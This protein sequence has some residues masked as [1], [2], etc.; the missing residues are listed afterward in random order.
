MFLVL[1]DTAT[2]CPVNAPFIL[3]ICLVNIF[4]LG[5]LSAYLFYLA[6][7]ARRNRPTITHG[8]WDFAGLAAGL[9]GFLI[10]GGGLVLHLF[11]SNFRSWMRG[12]LENFRAAWNSDKTTWMLLSAIYGLSV[13][14]A[15]AVTMASRRR[16]LVVYNIDSAEFEAVLAE[17]FEQLGRPIERRGKLWLSGGSPLFELDHFEGGRTITLRWISDDRHLSH[18]VDRLLRESVRSLAPEENPAG[19]WLMAFAGGAVFWAAGSLALM[20]VYVFSLK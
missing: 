11:Q 14:T 17:L 2:R 4:C 20:L 5:P 15:I 16:S 18:E 6:V 8:A 1:T 7:L 12:N 10:F 19:A 9:S 3:V 13:L